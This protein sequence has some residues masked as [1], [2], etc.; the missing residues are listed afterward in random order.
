MKKARFF[1]RRVNRTVTASFCSNACR[2]CGAWRD[3]LTERAP[4]PGVVGH[5]QPVPCGGATSASSGEREASSFQTAFERF[6]GV[7]P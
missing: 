5:P 4:S 7:K 1:C 2:L 6:F 3:Y